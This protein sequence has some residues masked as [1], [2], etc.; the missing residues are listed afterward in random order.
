MPT[1]AGR[2]GHAS[3]STTSK[4]YAHSVLSADERA[5]LVIDKM[6]EKGNKKTK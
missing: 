5:A 1:V 6:I 4:I 3:P 2:L